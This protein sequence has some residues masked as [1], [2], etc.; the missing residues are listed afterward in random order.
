[1]C[2]YKKSLTP[3]LPVGEVAS[4]IFPTSTFLAIVLKIFTHSQISLWKV[5]KAQK[6][7]Q[8]S[9]GMHVSARTG[10]NAC[11]R[12]NV[13]FPICLY[14][15]FMWSIVLWK[16]M[17]GLNITYQIALHSLLFM[18][19]TTNQTELQSQRSYT[20]VGF[21]FLENLKPTNCFHFANFHMQRSIK[22]KKWK[23]W[24]H[25]N[26][27]QVWTHQCLGWC[28]VYSGF[29]SLQKLNL[30]TFSNEL[31]LNEIRFL[32]NLYPTNCLNV[33]NFYVKTSTMLKK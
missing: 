8:P 17:E 22:L 28:C 11:H 5:A 14:P 20:F 18:M 4:Q 10:P 27:W 7:T 16:F 6:F 29:C 26:F 25:V 13:G 33:A 15:S 32:L 23:D 2:K 12:S 31:P 21:F 3:S 1:M 9:S 19:H 24:C 30:S